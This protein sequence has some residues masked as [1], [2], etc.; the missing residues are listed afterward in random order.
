VKCETWRCSEAAFKKMVEDMED[1][2]D[3]KAAKAEGGYGRYSDLQR[4]LGLN[5]QNAARIQR[6]GQR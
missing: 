3:A 1:L 2:S 5:I 6:E 4:S